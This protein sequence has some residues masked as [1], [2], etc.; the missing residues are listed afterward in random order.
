MD[1]LNLLRLFRRHTVVVVV[2]SFVALGMLVV[3]YV[4][5]PAVYRASGSVVLLNPPT[6][7]DPLKAVTPTLATTPPTLPFQN[8]FVRFNDISVVVDILVRVM[9]TSAVVDVLGEAGLNGTYTI[10]ANTD[11]YRGPIID[12]AAE[13]ATAGEAK[14]SA[15]LVM[16]ELS[17]QLEKLQVEQGGNPAYFIRPTTVVSPERATTVF[18]SVLRRLIAVGALGLMVIVVSAL[19]AEALRVA[20]DRRSASEARQGPEPIETSILSRSLHVRELTRTTT[21]SDRVG[22]DHPVP[23]VRTP[24]PRALG[25][26]DAVEGKGNQRTRAVHPYLQRSLQATNDDSQ[27][28]ESSRI[29]RPS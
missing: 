21:I 16:A 8:P 1:V 14:N 4:S 12:V 17:T 22:Q 24:V 11:F 2:A 18:S 25:V 9:R 15:K 28:D 13:A 3:S 23:E 19:L 5:A 7:P 26:P 10:G 29:R 6:P 20:R 27:T